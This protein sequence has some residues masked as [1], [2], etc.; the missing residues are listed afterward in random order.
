MISRG[1][2]E[3]PRQEPERAKTQTSFAATLK[4]QFRRLAQFLTPRE[5]P[6]P[7]PL[8]RRRRTEETG[9]G[10]KLAA[11]QIMRRA[12]RLPAAA[13]AA[14]AYLSDTLDWLNLWHQA[15]QLHDDFEPSQPQHLYPHL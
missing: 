14:V 12:V 7:K 4:E 13:Y 3:I 5:A 10:F 1:D 11:R 6:A 2:G 15:D 8:Q 9:G